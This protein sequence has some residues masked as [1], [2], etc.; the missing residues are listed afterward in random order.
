LLR[1]GGAEIKLA[2]LELTNNGIT[3]IGAFALGRSLQRFQ[4]GQ[5]NVSLITL[6]LD[7]NTTLGT[8]GVAALCLGLRTNSTLKKLSLKYCNLDGES[9][10]PLGEVLFNSQ[11]GLNILDLQGNRLGAPYYEKDDNGDVVED[12]D[13]EPVVASTGLLDLCPGLK[14]NLNLKELI[15]ADNQI[16]TSEWDAKGLVTF[17]EAIVN[18]PTLAKVDLLYNRI[19]KEKTPE[20]KEYF[21]AN[22]DADPWKGANALL[23]ATDGATGGNKNISTFRIDA[24]IPDEIF[25]K[26]N[27]MG[28]GGK[29]GKKGKKKKC[30]RSLKKDIQLLVAETSHEPAL[31]SF[32][33]KSDKSEERFHVGVMA[34]DLRDS[35]NEVWQS[36]VEEVIDIDD[37]NIL[38]VDEEF[39]E[40]HSRYVE[41]VEIN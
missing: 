24:S 2:Y 28:G 6:N 7:H 3:E 34:Q 8:N 12:E 22:S 21:E 33:Y 5:A 18:H 13:G 29:K 11:C 32:R 1:L 41:F 23:A 40:G 17:A 26:L 20:E 19:A 37:G 36:M 35:G 25:T 38:V 30:D 16:S 27:K 15:L 39:V 14:I 4:F 10:G 9:G 31:Y